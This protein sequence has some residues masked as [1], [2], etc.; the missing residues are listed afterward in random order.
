MDPN[1]DDDAPFRLLDL[2]PELQLLVTKHI[3]GNHPRRNLNTFL[4][5]SPECAALA[6]VVL[7]HSVA[8]Y[9]R[10][11]EHP[12]DHNIELFK[13][14]DAIAALVR[15]VHFW[16]RV[17]STEINVVYSCCV[18]PYYI[19]KARISRADVLAPP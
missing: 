10:D 19:L 12:F 3:A 13:S 8:I 15:K 5:A 14:Y 11:D 9:A 18:C 1:V 16:G 6:R 2:S 4:N 17:R 7:Y